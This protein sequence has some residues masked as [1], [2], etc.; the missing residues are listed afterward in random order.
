MA[1]EPAAPLGA[2]Q[3]DRLLLRRFEA[4]DLDGLGKVFGRPEVWEHPYGRAFSRNETSRFLEA[5]MQ[6]WVECGFGCWIALLR[7]TQ[8]TIGYVGLSVPTFSPKVLRAVEDAAMADLGM[9]SV[10]GWD[11]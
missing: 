1:R 4:T 9:D 11:G 8:E 10:E 3:T 6:E 2:V 7:E 5:Q